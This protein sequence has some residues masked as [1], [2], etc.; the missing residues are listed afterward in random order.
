MYRII[1]QVILS[2][3]SFRCVISEKSILINHKNKA[4]INISSQKPSNDKNTQGKKYANIQTIPINTQKL[5]SINFII[6]TFNF[7]Y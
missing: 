7:K 2:L 5:F 6:Q 3:F 4:I 1:S